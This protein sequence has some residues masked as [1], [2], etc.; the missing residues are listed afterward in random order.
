V[1]V[2]RLGDNTVDFFYYKGIHK[3]AAR[4]LKITFLNGLLDFITNKYKTKSYTKSK[5]IL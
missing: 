1:S 5:K 3:K 4:S 2:V